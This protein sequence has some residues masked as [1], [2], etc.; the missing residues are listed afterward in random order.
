M[1]DGEDS[2]GATRDGGATVLG[3]VM[4]VAGE[5]R[6]G[7]VSSND[8]EKSVLRKKQGETAREAAGAGP[9]IETCRGKVKRGRRRGNSAADEEYRAKSSSKPKTLLLLW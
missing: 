7:R 4:L 1:G 5:R 2:G 9:W 6:R 3:A 8:L